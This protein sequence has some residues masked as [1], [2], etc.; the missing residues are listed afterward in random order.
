M[1]GG[2]PL[3]RDSS[4]TLN[5]DD[6]DAVVLDLDGVVT[7]TARLHARAWKEAFDEYLD[8]RT[9]AGM[10]PFQRFDEVKDYAA[11]VDGKPRMDGIRSFLSSMRVSL[12]EGDPNSPKPDTIRGIGLR[13]NRLYLDLLRAEGPGIYDDAVDQIRGWKALGLKAAIVSS[14]RNCDEVLAAAGLDSLFDVRVDG[15]A[16]GRLGLAGKPSPDIFLEAARKLGVPPER[17]VIFEDAEAGVRAGRRGGFGLV[18][19]VDRMG[20]AEA[21]RRNGAD[22]VVSTL[23][24]VRFAPASGAREGLPAVDLPSALEGLEDM[25][26]LLKGRKAVVFLDYDGTLTP[27]V[28]RPELAVLSEPM[29]RTLKE[30]AAVCTVAVVSGRDRAD[31]EK[32]VDLDGLVYA[33]SHGYDIA[34]PE[35]LK[36]ELEE[37]KALLPLL[38]EVQ[39]R[40]DDA[41]SRIRGAL[42][43]RKRFSVA[44]HYRNVA[45]TEVADVQAAVDAALGGR[46]GLRKRGGKKVYELQP[47]LDWDKGAAVRWLLGALDLDGPDV[48][49]FYAGDDL[50]DEDAFRALAGRGIGIVV[51]AGD[52][53]THAAYRLADTGEVR[54]FLEALAGLVGGAVR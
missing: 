18:V 8:R 42:V 25:S 23:R 15:V 51:D 27:I 12:A 40:L 52:R 13:K 34:G 43:E 5:L 30:L 28:S 26:G 53:N 16:A 39:R 50:T 22:V 32:L 48:L 21:L 54:R 4:P 9:A 33:G 38:D 11:Y 24:M 29:R 19:G 20:H 14:S 3:N 10:P 36:K 1:N 2:V 7:R 35:G 46:E 37:A 17:A 44:V 41:L 6:F 31:V 45:P 47:D 49:P